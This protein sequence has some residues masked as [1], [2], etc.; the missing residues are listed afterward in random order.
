LRRNSAV[1]ILSEAILRDFDDKNG[2]AGLSTA[3]TLL[4][5][6]RSITFVNKILYIGKNFSELS[7]FLNFGSKKV[8]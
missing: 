8:M 6:C 1:I 5:R 3:Q 2:F 4:H 7:P